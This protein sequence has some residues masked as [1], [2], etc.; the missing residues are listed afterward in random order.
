M[1]FYYMYMNIYLLKE[2]VDT[3]E[4]LHLDPDIPDPMGG[5]REQYLECRDIIASAV[6]KIVTL[7]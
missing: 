5:T 4:G 2:F 1:Y 7:L 6:D 3:E